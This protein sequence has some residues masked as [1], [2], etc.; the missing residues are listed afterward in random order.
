M[1]WT[2]AAWILAAGLAAIVFAFVRRLGPWGRV[3]ALGMRLIAAGAAVI[4]FILALPFILG[5]MTQV[6]ARQSAGLTQGPTVVV[7]FGTRT[8]R[9]EIPGGSIFVN[10]EAECA[11]A[12]AQV[13]PLATGGGQTSPPTATIPAPSATPSPTTAPVAPTVGATA[14]AT[15]PAAMPVVET[16]LG[17]NVWGGAQIA[18]PKSPAGPDELYVAH[19]D[20]DGSGSCQVWVWESGR[21]VSGLSRATWQLYL[22]S[23]G[24][25]EDRLAMVASKQ[26]AAAAQSGTCPMSFR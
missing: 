1:W 16:H 9:C 19:G 26:R 12:R 11:V 20:V 17:L 24:I 10:D 15:T 4:M 13:T 5:L 18:L 22:I 6:V 25:R 2:I 7:P 14:T 23:G 21:Q 3:T 8:Y